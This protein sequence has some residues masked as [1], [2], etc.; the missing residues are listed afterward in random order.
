MFNKDAVHDWSSHYS[1]CLRYLAVVEQ[2]LKNTDRV[3]YTPTNRYPETRAIIKTYMK[4]KQNQF[5]HYVDSIMKSMK[6]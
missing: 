1:D 5:E 6:K 4:K 3:S 2:E